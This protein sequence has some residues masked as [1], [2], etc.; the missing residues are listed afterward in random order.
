MA[1][2]RNTGG[3]RPPSDDPNEILKQIL[4]ELKSIRREGSIPAKKKP[5]NPAQRVM[6]ES[7]ARQAGFNTAEEYLNHQATVDERYENRIEQIQQQGRGFR[8]FA[9]RYIEAQMPD[10]A[11]ALGIYGYQQSFRG[12]RAAKAYAFA[13]MARESMAFGIPKGVDPY[14]KNAAGKAIGYKDPFDLLSKQEQHSIYSSP[15]FAE[16]VLG[17]SREEVSDMAPHEREAYARYMEAHTALQSDDLNPED[18][19]KAL[20]T[21]NLAAISLGGRMLKNPAVAGRIAA[22]GGPAAKAVAAASAIKTPGPMV[23]AAMRMGFSATGAVMTAARLAGPVGMALT[24]AQVAYGT[25]DALYAPTRAGAALGY[26][27]TA[28]PFDYGARVT[29]GRSL[30]TNYDALMSFGLSGKQTAAARGALEGMGVGGRGS[31]KTY[32]AY[33]RSMTGVMKETGLDAEQLAPFYENFLRSGNKNNEIMKL[34]DLLENDLPKAAASARM[35]LSDMAASIT[36]ATTAVAASP[37]NART[38]SEIQASITNG[39]IG[40]PKGTEGIAGGMNDYLAMRVA[41]QN[42]GMSFLQ[43]RQE[44][45]LMQGE[46]AS[47][48]KEMA[49]DMT[50]EEFEE[51]RKTDQ[52]LMMMPVLQTM[53]QLT[54]DQMQTI[55][56]TGLDDYE[57]VQ[58]AL[59]ELDDT[60]FKSSGE[61][62]KRKGTFRKGLEWAAVGVMPS[63]LGTNLGRDGEDT[64]SS[65]IKETGVDVF[66][67]SGSE[68]QEYYKQKGV[69]DQ[70]RSGLEGEDLQKF[71][72]AMS[73]LTGKN[74]GNEVV[75]RLKEYAGKVSDTSDTN[76]EGTILGVFELSDDAKKLVKFTASID[77]AAEKVSDVMDF[78]ATKFNNLFG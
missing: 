64:R 13:E 29:T 18:K 31:E 77:G 28:N 65:I 60:N 42:P 45:N 48:L 6:Y 59:S 78:G 21:R 57:G 7:L 76:K 41:T 32:N 52:G 14:K 56:N 25:G 50:G 39:M 23:A 34:T 2:T 38:T 3:G 24:A 44:S 55:Y 53:T 36:A 9:R 10:P 35:S 66:K 68:I 70:I 1:P 61:N 49:G 74:E 46:A 75:D 62:K 71:D 67:A 72:E 27:F 73:D 40:A 17:L 16:S 20:R 5:L 51:W 11:E 47:V 63:L 69:Y 22:L 37:L 33:Y 4:G 58:S 19:G 15:A 30:Q 54:P 12:T 43:A 8:G 26:G